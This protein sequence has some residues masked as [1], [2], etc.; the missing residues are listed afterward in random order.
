MKAIIIDDE[1]D[2]IETITK[3]VETYCKEVTIVGSASSA[4]EGIKLINSCCPD[5]VFLDIEMP[6][7]NGFDLVEATK[8]KN[9]HI[10]FTTAYNHYAIKAIKVNALDYLMKPIDI[11]ELIEAVK[12]VNSLKQE[13][14]SQLT[15]NV[16][17]A[18]K[19]HQIRKLPVSQK[20][21][22]LFIDVDDIIYFNSDGAYT[23][24][25]TS[26]NKL[27]SS[28]NLKYYDDMFSE[29]GFYR[30]NNSYLIN[31]N[32]IT[33]YLREDGGILQMSNRI[34]I[35]ISKNKKDQVK[36]ILGL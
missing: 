25:I 34:K 24:I 10:I 20:G 36:K 22:Y 15:N 11:D 5:I 2:G 26:D 18:V 28:K 17:D 16:I 21:E 14:R 7:G 12:K 9:Y 6:H 35:L 33:K 32:H 30:V 29:N 27:L 31:L 19:H 1:R 23:H 8:D 3:M 13:H 4:L